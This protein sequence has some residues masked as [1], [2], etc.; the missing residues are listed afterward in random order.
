MIAI[1]LDNLNLIE[2]SEEL[3]RIIDYKKKTFE[4]KNL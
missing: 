2:I 1:Y 3:I 4:M